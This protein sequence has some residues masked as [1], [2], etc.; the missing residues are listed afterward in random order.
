[1]GYEGPPYEGSGHFRPPPSSGG[2]FPRRGRPP[3]PPPPPPSSVRIQAVAATVIKGVGGDESAL[4][5][6]PKCGVPMAV[7]IRMAPCYHVMCGACGLKSKESKKCIVC[8]QPIKYIESLSPSVRWYICKRSGR[9]FA[10]AKDL[11]YSDFIEHGLTQRLIRRKKALLRERVEGPTRRPKARWDKQ[12]D[13]SLDPD[14]MFNFERFLEAPAPSQPSAAAPAPP[15]QPPRKRPADQA[16]ESGF[17]HPAAKEPKVEAAAPKYMPAAKSKPAVKAAPMRPPAAQ[18]PAQATAPLPQL[19]P[20][21]PAQPVS[22]GGL[23][24]ISPGS[25]HSPE[26]PPKAGDMMMDDLLGLANQQQQQQ[27]HAG[28]AAPSA[29]AGGGGAK[30]GGMTMASMFANQGMG[31]DDFDL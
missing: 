19:V 1:M 6:C 11:A 25:G 21:P 3:P 18:R 23:S 12:E 10:T 13:D 4:T 30:K 17:T 27:Q 29:A 24:P 8:Y 16:F 14:E 28:A 26:G 15:P 31:D 2:W 22:A 7:K 5:P 20:V 9:A